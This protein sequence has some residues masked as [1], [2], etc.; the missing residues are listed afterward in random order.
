MLV[1]T[2]I[3]ELQHGARICYRVLLQ[4]P[5]VNLFFEKLIN[6]KVVLFLI[7]EQFR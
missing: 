5:S 4:K 1:L 2:W 6:I 3:D 7:H